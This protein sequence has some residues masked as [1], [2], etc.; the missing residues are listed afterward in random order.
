[1]LFRVHDHIRKPQKERTTEV[2]NAYAALSKGK[3]HPL[4]LVAKQIDRVDN[5]EKQIIRENC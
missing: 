3:K 4:M 5:E 1:M 2:I